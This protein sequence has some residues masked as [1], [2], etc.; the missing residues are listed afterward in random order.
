MSKGT[1]PKAS[2]AADAARVALDAGVAHAR[3]IES[4]SSIAL[5]DESGVLKA[6]VR[7]DG[8]PLASVQIAQ[9]KAYTAVGFRMA[10][11]EWAQYLEHD[12][13]L[14]VGSA[15]VPRMIVFGGGVPVSVDGEVVGA[16]GVSGGDYD[17]DAEVAAAVVAALTGEGA[18]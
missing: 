15:N 7:M 8:A 5:V 10:T 11:A 13:V 12:R 6:F 14:A 2:V 3:A 16:V 9:D 1:F 4:P 17:Q 18:P